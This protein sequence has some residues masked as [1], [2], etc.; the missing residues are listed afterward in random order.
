MMTSIGGIVT[1]FMRSEASK[2]LTNSHKRFDGP[3][4]GGDGKAGA[5]FQAFPV[6]VGQNGAGG[7]KGSE[8]RLM[9]VVQG[10]K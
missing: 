6:I 2:S 4:G 10:T 1:P 7:K 3:E 5:A 8:S 9:G